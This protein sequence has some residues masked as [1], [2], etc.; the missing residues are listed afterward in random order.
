V[1]DLLAFGNLRVGTELAAV[2]LEL[3]QL[4]HV[5]DLQL[6]PAPNVDAAIMRQL[7]REP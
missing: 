2:G 6:G 5:H 4:R 7:A 3:V 1:G